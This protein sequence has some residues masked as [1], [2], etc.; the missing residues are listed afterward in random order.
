MG[1]LGGARGSQVPTLNGT[2]QQT[3][4]RRYSIKAAGWK[5]PGIYGKDSCVLEGQRSLRDFSRNKGAGLHCFLPPAPNPDTQ[6]PAGTST[7]REHSSP[8]LL[9]ACPILQG[10]LT[11]VHHSTRILLL[12]YR[13]L[14]NLYT[15]FFFLIYTFNINI[16]QRAI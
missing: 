16:F 3:A 4:A 7:Q 13:L 8:N 10:G 14:A 1:E 15:F 9:T 6:T 12:S 2:A 11:A 5:M